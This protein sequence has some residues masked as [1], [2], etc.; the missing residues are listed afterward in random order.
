MKQSM[1]EYE[2]KRAEALEEFHCFLKGCAKKGLTIQQLT[3]IGNFANEEIKEVIAN[4]HTQMIFSEDQCD[5]L[6]HNHE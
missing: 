3:M 5:L 2:K 4:I 1:K 6:Q